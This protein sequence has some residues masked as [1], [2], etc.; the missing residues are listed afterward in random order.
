[1]ESSLKLSYSRI[2][3]LT[4]GE[5]FVIYKVYRCYDR[6]GVV[7]GWLNGFD[8]KVF[9]FTMGLS[10][11]SFMHRCMWLVSRSGDWGKIWLAI[12]LFLLYWPQNRRTSEVCMITLLF[13]TVLGEGV[14]KRIFRRPRP[15]VTHGPATL[16]IPE[17]NGFSF[18]SGHTASS[19]ACARILAPLNPWLAA[20]VYAYAGL[21]A[22]S[23]VY[24]KVH[25][26]TDVVAGS[27]IGI[28]CAKLVKWY[29]M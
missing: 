1:M 11:E 7:L 2:F 23:R 29:F 12:C 3:N 15:Y 21:M 28:I 4:L 13:T 18:P 6:G 10:H 27:V 25:Y 14:L 16:T 22:V 26:V 24:L 8:R 9:K 20:A 17:P 5:F 19:V